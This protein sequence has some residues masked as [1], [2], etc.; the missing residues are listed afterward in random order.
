MANIYSRLVA[1]SH[2][3]KVFYA[4]LRTLLEK[5]AV[6]FGGKH[7]GVQ[8]R[9]C[10]LIKECELEGDRSDACDLSRGDRNV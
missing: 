8:F 10:R 4:P 3:W 2:F 5:P 9:N 1:N 7:P 6:S